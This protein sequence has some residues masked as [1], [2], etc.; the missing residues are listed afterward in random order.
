MWNKIA[1]FIL[2]KKLYLLIG[3]GLIIGFMVYEMQKVE[4]DYRYTNM[5]SESDAAYTDN[6]KFKS[7]FGDEATGIIVGFEDSSFF[8][9][10]KF[11]NLISLCQDLKKVE[12][13]TNVMT[14][15]DAISL[16][17]KTFEDT[18]ENKKK[19]EFE[20]YRIFPQ[21]IQNKEEL[22][23]LKN[24]FFKLPFY[25]NLLYNNEKNTYLLMIT[26]AKEIINTA[27]RIPVDKEINKLVGDFSKENN[28]KIHISGHPH[29]R[30]VIMVETKHEIILFTVLAS[31]ICIIILLIFFRSIKVVLL[32]LLVVG[33]SISCSVGLM[34]ILDYKITILTAMIPPLLIVIG[35]PNSVYLI[36]KFFCELRS[37][38]NKTLSLQ[39][40]IS[41]TG[42]AV[43]VTNITTAAGFFTFVVTRNTY[44]VE[45]GIIASV[46]II[47]IF[48]SSLIIIPGF[49]SYFKLPTENYV[50]RIEGKSTK[51]IVDKIIKIV[52]NKRKYAYITFGIILI[53]SIFGITKIARSG[54]ILDDVKHDHILYKDLKFLENHFQGA[55]PL[56]IVIESKDSLTSGLSMVNEIEKIDS[57]QV[58]LEKYPILSKSM[59][60][61]NFAKFLY[62]GYSKGNPENYKLPPNA[63]TYETILSRLP[64]FNNDL[65]SKFIDSTRRITRIS[66]NVADIGTDR[67]EEFLPKI[68]KDIS[69]VFPA[70][71]YNTF[72][73]GSTIMYFVSNTYLTSNLLSSLILAIILI[74]GFMFW[75][76][77]S[78]RIVLISILP[79]L[80]PMIVTAGIMGFFHIPIKPST[81]LVFGIIFGISVDDTIHYLS[82]F[83]QELKIQNW[84]LANS[85]RS[86]LHETGQSMI[87]TSIILICGFMIFAFSSFG[88][89]I[90]LGVLATCAMF[91]AMFSNIV[92][93]PSLLLTFQKK[94][95]KMNHKKFSE[96]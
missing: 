22:D 65:T 62:Q 53:L 78:P 94:I 96:E 43:A 15:S 32:T 25:Q 87:Y 7:I 39:R 21:K 59:S 79:N 48:L 58:R 26:V 19:R 83:R 86:A 1:V 80:I 11:N 56:E 81:I 49:F 88:G 74:I 33:F 51:R 90:A 84:N 60:V 67:M 3:L 89:T 40:V 2:R 35:I 6:L 61:A 20:T 47:C 85:V 57:L 28:V 72:I 54:Y 93:L 12:H 95:S 69:E 70:D 55:F 82:R 77:R 45:F 52:F 31:I 34:G 16:R 75:M 91:I 71:Q 68:K 29:I 38:G 44:L 42:A 37:H 46:G 30:S 23:S 36:N 73:T 92:L 13:V 50:Q 41:M 17:M 5:L 10:E 4:M 8:E 9:V 64:K 66:V 18:V 27:D 24:E 14:V 63:K 76:F